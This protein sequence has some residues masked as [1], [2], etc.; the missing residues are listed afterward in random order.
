MLIIYFIVTFIL[1]FVI[2]L[3]GRCTFIESFLM[4]IFVSICMTGIILFGQLIFK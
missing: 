4:S 3:W 2:C 1:T